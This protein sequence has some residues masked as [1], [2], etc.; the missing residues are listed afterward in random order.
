M[1]RNVRRK[2]RTSPMKKWAMDTAMMIPLRT[3][4]R[5]FRVALLRVMLRAP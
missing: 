1:A 4:A 2:A 3:V 5:E